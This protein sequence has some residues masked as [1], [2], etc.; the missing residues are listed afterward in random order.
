M[1]STALVLFGMSLVLAPAAEPFPVTSPR[2]TDR[3]VMLAWETDEEV[4]TLRNSTQWS[5]SIPTGP[6][7]EAAIVPDEGR[8]GSAAARVRGKQS[9]N[10][11]RGCFIQNLEASHAAGRYEYEIF[12][13]TA[14]Q[15][16]GKARLVID[17]YVGSS[18]EHHGLV[19]R[20]LPA[21]DEWSAVRGSFDLPGDVQLMRCLVYQVGTGTSWFDDVRIAPAGS[22]TNFLGDAGFDG[23]E[24][25]RVYYRIKSEAEWQPVEAVVLERFHNV[26]FLEPA[27]EYEFHVRRVGS[28][29]S[30]KAESQVLAASTK[31]AEPR[32]WNRFEIAPDQA[33]ATPPAVYPCIESVDG[34]L[35]YSECRGGTIWLSQLDKDLRPL[36]T[37][38]WV[39]PFL[40][41]GKPCYQGQT[42]SAVL[43]GKLY[44]SWKR[45]YHGDAPHARQCVASYDTRSGEIAGPFVIEPN[46][47]AESTWNGG[48]AAVGGQ[49]WV[50]YCRWQSLPD[51]YRTTVTVRTLDP[52]LTDLGPAHELDSQPTATPYTPFLSVFDGEL[53]V[54][55]TDSAA[56][57]DA[58]PLWLVR[59]NGQT[60]HDLITVSAGGFNQY[61]KGV[62]V[63]DRLALV[64]K[65]GEPYP[66]RIY[67]RYM[68]HDV[69]LALVDPRTG[70]VEKISLVDDV[71]YN[72][73][74]DITWHEG[75]LVYVYNKFEHLYG[76]RND[77][78]KLYGCFIGRL[79]PITE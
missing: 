16:E 1:A 24:S 74:P 12:Y 18:R 15:Q 11:A 35:Y 6:S 38:A 51:G 72:S 57:T 2:Q 61:A 54:T 26:I 22:P 37:K 63:G 21:A 48:I 25:W 8:A 70:S 59:F 79:L 47:P 69:G 53:A 29:G 20:D 49:L 52:G 50:S 56:K 67:G 30:V 17:C 39:E 58:Q 71:K 4:R 77:P 66:S 27:T 68:F 44:L 78:G 14:D 32:V 42:Q 7:H 5:P 13:R 65:Y 40:V 28:D 76:G 64:W 10:N 60:F 31:P 73:S 75:S 45:A 34:A 43:D 3:S 19:S 46:D 23:V 55:F 62:Q 41:D 9:A 36:W 33:M